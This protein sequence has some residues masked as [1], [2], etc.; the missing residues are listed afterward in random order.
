MTV[1]QHMQAL[2]AAS[3]AAQEQAKVRHT[4]ARLNHMDGRRQVATLLTGDTVP[5]A[6]AMR[7]E[8]L[9]GAVRG[10]GECKTRIA[11]REI[12]V[13]S[14][15]RRVRELTARQR[16]VLA[17]LLTDSRKLRYGIGAADEEAA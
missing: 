10:W 5:A 14:Y 11:L 15:G 1:P 7:I 13:R 12:Q 9:L 16:G 8:R 6:E 2:N 4:I 3:R 17:D